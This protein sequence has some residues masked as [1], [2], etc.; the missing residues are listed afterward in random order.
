[1]VC[2][3]E[4][5]RKYR[6]SVE[7]KAYAAAYGKAYF[8]TEKGLAIARYSSRKYAADPANY[9]KIR[10]LHLGNSA[11]S[12]GVPFNITHED[13]VTPN[14]CPVLGIP[15]FRGASKPGPNSPSV[16]RIIPALGYVKGNV[17]VISYLANTMKQNATPEQ[18]LTFCRNMPQYLAQTGVLPA[19]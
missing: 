18:L 16:D 7:G 2:T 14:V 19:P 8:Q 10:C 4:N 1:M 15:I 3:R 9:W 12:A 17:R 11:R 6:N 13:L 5:R